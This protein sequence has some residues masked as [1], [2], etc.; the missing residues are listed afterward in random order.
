MLGNKCSV[1]GI[2]HGLNHVNMETL[3][4]KHPKA[5]SAQAFRMW[6]ES[7]SLNVMCGYSGAFQYQPIL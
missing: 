3:D 5:L 2:S 1:E 4:W 6:L 7:L